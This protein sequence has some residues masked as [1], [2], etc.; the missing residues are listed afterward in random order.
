MLVKLARQIFYCEGVAVCEFCRER[1][2]V[3][4]DDV[5]VRFGKYGIDDLFSGLPVCFGKIVTVDKADVFE[6][7]Y[8]EKIFK[9]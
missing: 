7:V 4:P 9:I 6:S 2:V 5:R 8:A 3:F 1:V